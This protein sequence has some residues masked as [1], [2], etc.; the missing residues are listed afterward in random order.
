MFLYYGK[1]KRFILPT[2]KYANDDVKTNDLKKTSLGGNSIFNTVNF[3]LMISHGSYGT[4]PAIDGVFYTYL[5]IENRAASM[6]GYLRLSDFSFGGSEPD[7][8]RWMTILGCGVLNENCWNSMVNNSR[9][10]IN[11][12]LHVLLSASTTIHE[13]PDLGQYYALALSQDRSIINAWYVTGRTSYA[14]T[15]G[16]NIIG[17]TIK[18]ASVVRDNCVGD[19]LRSYTTSPSGGLTFD[20]EQIYP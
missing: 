9:N 3:G 15:T 6:V 20:D 17:K 13:I 2:F 1:E 5:W 16:T 18:F 11:S 19:T 4:V 7:G 8:L 12:N 14:T 10:S